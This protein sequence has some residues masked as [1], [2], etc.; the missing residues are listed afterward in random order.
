MVK[1]GKNYQNGPKQQ[2][3]SKWSKMVKMTKMV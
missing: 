1:N 2:I 3:C